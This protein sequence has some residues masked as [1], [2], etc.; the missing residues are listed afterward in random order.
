MIVFA[1]A[2]VPVMTAFA[3]EAKE[4][5]SLQLRLVETSAQKGQVGP[6]MTGIARIELFLEA[7]RATRDI[8]ISVTRP[9]GSVWTSKGRRFATG[10]LDWSGPGG[11]P[12]EPQEPGAGA[13]V[14]R[15]L[16]GMKTMIAVPLE[17]ANIHE[18]VV[19]ATGLMEGES[20]T[21]EAVVRAPLGVPDNQPVDDGERAHFSLQGVN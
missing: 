16:G 10:P 20:V 1:A 15:A 18:I 17:G 21:T 2:V 8:Q 4:D 6:S 9:D 5:F 14:L 11:E 12:L 7:F 13:P 3:N 19:K